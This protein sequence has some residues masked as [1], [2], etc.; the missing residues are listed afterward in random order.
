LP[1]RHR[2]VRVVEEAAGVD[3][4]LFRR[5]KD[6]PMSSKIVVSAVFLAA[7]LAACSKDTVKPPVTAH[8]A[9][10][11]PAPVVKPVEKK[12]DDGPRV[13]QAVTN[14]LGLDSEILRV[15]NLHIDAHAP[16]AKEGFPHFDFDESS[17]SA[18]DTSVLRQVAQCLTTGPL[19]GRHL[20]LVGRADIRGTTEYNFVLGAH[21]ASTVSQFLERE[22][23]EPPRIR[24]TSR[25]ELDAKGSDE[26]GMA[27][28]RRVDILLDG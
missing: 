7:A 23:V 19:A 25:G 11:P 22:G 15:C 4:C 17:L 10:P 14:L 27:E 21:R 13:A 6:T 20:R 18:E 3:R 8:A 2:S 28:D 9:P 12:A 24:E 16:A 1:L 26:A 5:R